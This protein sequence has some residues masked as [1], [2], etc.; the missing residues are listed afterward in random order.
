M[1]FTYVLSLINI[2][3]VPKLLNLVIKFNILLKKLDVLLL[4]L[5]V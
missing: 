1:D 5:V 2:I 4:K 3:L